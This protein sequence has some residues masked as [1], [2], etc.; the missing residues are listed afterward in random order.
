MK[1]DTEDPSLVII[2]IVV[3]VTVV[4]VDLHVVSD[5]RIFMVHNYSLKAP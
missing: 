3:A 2:V 5:P 1:F 4:V